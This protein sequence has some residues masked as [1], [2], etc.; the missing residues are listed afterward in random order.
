MT[1]KK[2]RR[3]IRSDDLADLQSLMDRAQQRDAVETNT[4]TKTETE[5]A[6]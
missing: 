5:N 1:T 6:R 3:P 2:L 4:T